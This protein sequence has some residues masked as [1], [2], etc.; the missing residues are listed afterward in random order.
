V[1]VPQED[2]WLAQTRAVA[3]CVSCIDCPATAQHVRQE[4]VPT[5]RFGVPREVVTISIN[6]AENDGSACDL[7]VLADFERATRLELDDRNLEDVSWRQDQYFSHGNKHKFFRSLEKIVQTINPEWTYESG[8][9]GHADVVSCVTRETW[10]QIGK[11]P[12]PGSKID[13]KAQKA[14][15][16]A[17]INNCRGHFLN[18]LNLLPS[19]CWILCDGRTAWN[20]TMGAGQIPR[21]YEVD[22]GNSRRV[23]VGALALGGKTFRVAGWNQPAHQLYSDSDK[24]AVA[25]VAKRL[26]DIA[27]LLTNW[28]PKDVATLLTNRC[29][30]CKF[31]PPTLPGKL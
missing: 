5:P 24:G 2:F 19:D 13:K 31:S 18:T 6:P 26:M 7:P 25:D 21:N 30:D 1:I 16:D 10:S 27:T 17:L 28:C 22:L 12:V 14:V 29:P 20:A 9:V 8:K 4:Y 23:F 3:R 11:S 15:Q